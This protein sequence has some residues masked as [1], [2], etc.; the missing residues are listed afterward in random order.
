MELKHSPE[1]LQSS[2]LKCE[3]K[4]SPI[5]DCVFLCIFKKLQ[6]SGFWKISFKNLSVERLVCALMKKS[7]YYIPCVKVCKFDQKR[8]VFP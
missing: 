6:K 3:G 4:F 2:S 1:V 5:R 8:N 7:K